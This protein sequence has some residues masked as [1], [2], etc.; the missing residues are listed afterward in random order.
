M[1]MFLAR[2]P[3]DGDG[4]GGR[5]RFADTGLDEHLLRE[6][7]TRYQQRFGVVSEPLR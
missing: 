3:G 2:H 6:R 4:G 5:Y 1:R 7:S